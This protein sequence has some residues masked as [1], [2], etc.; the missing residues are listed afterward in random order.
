MKKVIFSVA[1]VATMVFA[2]CSGEKKVQDEAS[3]MQSKIEN[4]TNPDSLKAYAA[5]AQA[6]YQKLVAE[7]KVDEAKAFLDKVEPTI[8]EKVPS[9]AGAFETLKS[10]VDAL[11][12][13]V[14]D[15]AS[16]VGDSISAAADQAQQA[17]NQLVHL[18]FAARAV[19]AR[20]L[21]DERKAVFCRTVRPC[22]HGRM[23]CLLHALVSFAA[24]FDTCHKYAKLVKVCL[25]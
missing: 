23:L 20:K 14:D 25:L 18:L 11:P 5:Q 24:A 7:G 6:Y 9:L 13:K 3:S 22:G 2:A 19:D 21:V 1:V 15:A 17:A 12:G 10:G 4:C 8:K 16:A